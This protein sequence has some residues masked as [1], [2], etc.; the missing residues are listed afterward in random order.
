MG[1]NRHDTIDD[2]GRQ[3][4]AFRENDGYYASLEVLDELFGPLLD[5]RA[6]EGKSIAD[7]GAGTGRFVRMFAQLGASRIVA[8]EPSE[9]VH[10]LKENLSDLKHV[11]IIQ[12]TADKLPALGFDYVFC[13]GVLQFILHP[14]PA[15]RAMGRAL[16]PNGKLFLWVYGR[17][18]TGIYLLLLRP[19][20]LITTRLPHPILSA[21]CNLLLIPTWLYGLLCRRFDLPFSRYMKEYFL[22]LDRYGKKLTIYDQ[23]NPKSVKYYK[24]EELLHLL[25]KCGFKDIRFHNRLGYSWSVTARYGRPS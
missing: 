8:L 5:K 17:E 20:R 25:E 14:E 19:L 2:F 11:E 21:I 9:A 22:K 13:I 24:R 18:Q 3:W 12:A 16:G 6:I 15:L 23:L 7:V 10:V 1:K 4:T